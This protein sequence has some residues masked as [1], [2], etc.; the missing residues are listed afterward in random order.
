MPFTVRGLGCGVQGLGLGVRVWEI[1]RGGRAEVRDKVLEF[2][3]WGLRILVIQTSTSLPLLSKLGKEN[4]V[5]AR[6]LP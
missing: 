1:C 6:V 2:G 4:P 5:K 3:D